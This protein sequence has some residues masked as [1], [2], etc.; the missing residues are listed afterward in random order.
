MIIPMA[1][2]LAALSEFDHA[3]LEQAK[4]ELS[5]AQWKYKAF[6]AKSKLLELVVQGVGYYLATEVFPGTGNAGLGH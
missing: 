4:A 1:E 2:I 5:V 6:E 3:S